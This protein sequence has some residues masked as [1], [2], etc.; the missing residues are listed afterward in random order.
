M[1]AKEWHTG[2]TEI[3]KWRPALTRIKLFWEEDGKPMKRP[4]R[5]ATGSGSTMPD[6]K[7]EEVIVKQLGRHPGN[8]ESTYYQQG[9]KVARAE[10]R[11][12]KATLK[13][14]RGRQ[15]KAAIA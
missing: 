5:A 3:R 2:N 6:W 12:L 15:T 14:I 7:K 1:E 10:Y 4:G 8:I 13:D 11:Q 9:D